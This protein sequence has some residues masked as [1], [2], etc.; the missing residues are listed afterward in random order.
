MK[1]GTICACLEQRSKARIAHRRGAQSEQWTAVPDMD[2]TINHTGK[3]L[4]SV[5]VGL[6]EVRL[7]IRP[8]A[9]RPQGFF[10]HTCQEPVYPTLQAMPWNIGGRALEL[11]EG[12]M[13]REGNTLSFSV[14]TCDNDPQWLLSRHPSQ[15][16][17]PA[18]LGELNLALTLHLLVQVWCARS[19]W[20]A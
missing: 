11:R 20:A 7:T 12:L 4:I 16:V 1:K 13:W 19:A 8:I 3:V 5:I 10:R 6:K 15:Y 18:T 17:H 2:C 9:H 14:T